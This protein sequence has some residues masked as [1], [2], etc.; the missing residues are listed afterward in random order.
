MRNYDI[1]FFFKGIG[2]HNYVLKKIG[3]TNYFS[4]SNTERILK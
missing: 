4:H 1:F 2:P 3:N